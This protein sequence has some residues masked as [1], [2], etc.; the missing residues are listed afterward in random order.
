MCFSFVDSPLSSWSSYT[1]VSQIWGHT[2][3]FL[4]FS[5]TGKN[6]TVNYH[7]LKY[8]RDFAEP[9]QLHRSSMHSPG[10]VSYLQT[11]T[12]VFVLSQCTQNS[13][14]FCNGWS[15]WHHLVLHVFVDPAPSQTQVVPLPA[16]S[17]KSLCDHY[18]IR[19]IAFI[20]AHISGRSYS[21][22]C[23]LWWEQCFCFVAAPCS[24][25]HSPCQGST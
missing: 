22:G 13:L 5:W 9:L 1:S 23:V 17:F 16:R 11:N 4:I 19:C 3:H 15:L 24:S 2:H 12:D 20:C 7:L 21:E 6:F 14:G 8:S 18:C 25:P 10:V